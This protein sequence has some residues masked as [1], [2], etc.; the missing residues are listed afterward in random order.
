MAKRL[1]KLDARIR[2]IYQVNSGLSN[3]RNTGISESIGEFL[4]FLDADD[5]LQKNKLSHFAEYIKTNPNADLLFAEGRLF[6]DHDLSTF[7]LNYPDLEQEHW[8]LQKSGKGD[9]IIQE[10][11]K[12]NR[13]LV[14]MPLRF[15]LTTRNSLREVIILKIQ[16]SVHISGL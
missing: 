7:L 2:Y 16:N 6:N 10:F 4:Q 9:E 12:F 3:A 11:L 8:T 5:L 15:L 1:C 13:F 14:N